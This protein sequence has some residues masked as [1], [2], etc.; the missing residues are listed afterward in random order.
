MIRNTAFRV[1]CGNALDLS[2][3]RAVCAHIS[4][5][6]SVSVWSGPQPVCASRGAYF[7][8]ECQPN[9]G[10]LVR[11]GCPWSSWPLS[12]S[13]APSCA[14]GGCIASS[15]AVGAR[16]ARPCTSLIL[17]LLRSALPPV[18]RPPGAHLDHSGEQTGNQTYGD[19]SF[20][21]IWLKCRFPF[22]GL[23]V[24]S[25]FSELFHRLT[26]INQLVSRLGVQQSHLEG[27]LHRTAGPTQQNFC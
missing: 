14:R 1:K 21:R 25:G 4:G 26:S 22:S 18:S 5:K 11:A 16:P 10:T 6:S 9:S 3:A 13:G 20:S 24:S 15:A 2:K 19:F 7:S 27:L 8:S 12:C 23:G 17:T